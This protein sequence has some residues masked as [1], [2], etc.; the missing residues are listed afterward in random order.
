MSGVRCPRH[1]GLYDLYDVGLKVAEYVDLTHAFAPD[2]PVWQAFGPEIVSA[3]TAS[4]P[5]DGFVSDGD[6]FKY[7][8]TA[9]KP[10]RTCC[11]RT[12]TV[13]SWILPRTGTSSVQRFPTFL[14]PLPCGLW[15]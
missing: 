5:I 1:R 7:G 3:G 12:S 10:R 6:E 15:S 13:L 14:R 9:F 8:F 4:V 11:R 2:S